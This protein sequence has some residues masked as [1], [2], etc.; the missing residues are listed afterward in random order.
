MYLFIDTETGGLTPD[1]S[2]LTVS[3]IPVDKELQI[4]PIEYYDPLQNTT[5]HTDAGLYLALKHD[6]YVVDK[7]ALAVNKLNVVEHD[8]SAV[9]LPLA[10]DLV[11]SFIRQVLKT[12]G[13][14]YLVPAG[15][16]V[17]FDVAFLKSQ[18]F[19]PAEWDEFFTYPFF[20]TAVT[21]RFLN[22]A[23]VIGSTGYSLTALRSKFLEGPYGEAHDAEV[24]NVMSL[25]LAQKFASLIAGPV[26]Q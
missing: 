21:A 24:D 2:L 10:H 23:G 12:V 26:P 11:C 14:K 15:H 19:T 5:S 7:Q 22:A 25:M 4:I 16:N 18:L 3:M 17:A 1:R 9:P 8:E 6:T 13:R 20:D